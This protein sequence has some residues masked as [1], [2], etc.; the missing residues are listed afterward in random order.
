MRAQQAVIEWLLD[1]DPAIRWQVMRDLTGAPPH[2]IAAE[3]AKVAAEGA[4]AR[5]LALQQ[6]DGRW[7]GVAWNHGWDSTLHVLWLL[8]EMG[9]DP[10]ADEAQRALRRV[11]DHVTW[12]GCGPREADHNR[13]FEGETEP[14]I[15][16]QVAAAGA[17]FRQDV[18]NII[19]RLLA[20]QLADGGWN[21]E[22][23]DRAAVIV[24][25]H[26]LRARGA[27]GIRAISGCRLGE[28]RRD[29][30]RTAARTG[31]SSRAPPVTAPLDG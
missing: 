9:L 7:G 3:R 23:P 26:D 22:A 13:F 19:A 14:C 28:H 20:E 29:R 4:G 30:G 6:P 18:R 25:H 15:N 2:E 27:A 5:L 1:S 21:C 11:R 8:R 16:A 24:Q 31:I 10:A 17:Y 12:Q